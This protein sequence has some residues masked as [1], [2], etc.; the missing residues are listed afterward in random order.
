[1][2]TDN[3]KKT[4]S[5][6]SPAP[7][8]RTQEH[9]CLITCPLIAAPP[10]VAAPALLLL[11]LLGVAQHDDQHAHKDG[12]DVD[13]EVQGCGGVLGNG[14]GVVMV[15]FAGKCQGCCI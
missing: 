13:E 6:K 9:D 7:N 2:A 1:M 15:S 4:R 3:Y 14:W 10:P 11:A 8:P 12:D 5:N